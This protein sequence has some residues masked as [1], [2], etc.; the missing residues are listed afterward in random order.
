MKRSLAA[1]VVATVSV[2]GLVSPGH[3]RNLR[4]TL[5]PKGVEAQGGAVQAALEP[6]G[7]VIGT[8][9]ANQIPTLS[10]S[11]GY[12]YEYNPTI[13]AYERS[14]STFGP[15]FSERAVTVGRNRFNVNASFTYI[16]FDSFNG[17]D[18]DNL[19]SRK[20][21]ALLNGQ[22]AYAGLRRRDLAGNFPSIGGNPNLAFTQVDTNLD[23]YAQLM[24]FSFTYGVLDNLD[25]N[26][27]L[28]VVRTY[29]ASHVRETTLDPRFASE[30]N[31]AGGGDIV[32]N[33]S[34]RNSALGIGDIRLRSKYL[35]LIDPVR[36][37]TLVDLAL[38]TG[39]P[40][41]FQGTG[42]TRL[43]SYVI[44][45]QTFGKIFEPHLQAGVEFNCDDVDRSQAK[46]LAG[47]TAQVA[48]MAALTIDFL[49][50]SEFAR[51]TH[52][53]SD[54]RLPAVENGQF[55]E[56]A[57]PFHG[58]PLFLTIKRNDVLDLAV[59]GKVS[60]APQAILFATVILPMNNDGLRADVVP[61]VGFE[62]TF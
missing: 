5:V 44:A 15:L 26:V 50:R 47:I 14:S 12:T 45:S 13:E 58:R 27:D 9:V 24:D 41:N 18:L 62:A 31:L 32:E 6:L 2:V 11:A 30:F 59:G 19:V 35:A 23:I 29:A 8:Q 10:T 39:S 17:H 21:S 22:P 46:Y 36:V 57:A 52:I 54:G 51:M 1:V 3:A 49:G 34:S 20:E 38:P 40:G 43:G 53:P 25:V 60:V 48:S 33:F 4:R 56:T 7:K 28:P 37:A 16:H 61:T 55:T 42:D